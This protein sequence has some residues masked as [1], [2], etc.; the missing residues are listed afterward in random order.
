MEVT[1]G[2]FMP[3][4][5][6]MIMPM[7]ATDHAGVD[8]PRR[9]WKAVGAYTE[10]LRKDRERNDPNGE[11]AQLH[12]SKKL[13][14]IGYATFT[15]IA[16]GKGNPTFDNLASYL[17]LIGGDLNE[18]WKIAKDLSITENKARQI[19]SDRISRNVA[20]KVVSKHGDDKKEAFLN[21]LDGSW[22]LDNLL[23]NPK[24]VRYVMQVIQ[25]FLDAQN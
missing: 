7:K 11:W 18:A 17:D 4:L 2:T 25:G 24:L 20:D 5:R 1:D 15:R 3:S 13:P 6:K 23:S 22:I 19:A 21:S 12:L 9:N 14:W 10:H 8:A 16:G